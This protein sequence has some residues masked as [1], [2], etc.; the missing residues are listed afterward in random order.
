LQDTLTY[1]SLKA[2][3][4]AINNGTVTGNIVIKIEGDLVITDPAILQASGTGNA[5]YTSVLIYP[6][7]NYTISGNIGGNKALITLLDADNVTIDGR[8]NATGATP[9]LTIQNLATATSA[10][11]W[12]ARSTTG[13]G[14][15]NVN[16]RYL[17]IVGGTATTA[18]VYGILSGQYSTT[19]LTTAGKNDS[20]KIFNNNIYRCGYGVRVNSPSTGLRT[21][22]LEIKNNDIG[23]NAIP[24]DGCTYGVDVAYI[25]GLTFENNIYSANITSTNYPFVFRYTSNATITNSKI[26]NSTFSTTTYGFYFIQTTNSNISNLT[27]ENNSCLAGT[28]YGLFFTTS[29]NGNNVNNLK[30]SNLSGASSIYGIYI[31]STSANN[32]IENVRIENL[33]STGTGTVSGVYNASGANNVFNKFTIKNLK[34]GGA[35]FGIYLSTAIT[36]I[37]KNSE[38]TNIQ[39]T[40]TYTTLIICGIYIGT[41][42]D[43]IQ[44]P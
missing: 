14:A 31:A 40:S 34:S 19:S 4:D 18:S 44:Q 39:T 36:N 37:V 23:N 3:F 32:S 7:G 20:L 41:S 25:D 15:T 16:L 42:S 12:V 24:G 43:G 22:A 21:F 2:A 9:S 29:S 10:C 5:N 13:N 35:V 26:I 30:I 27:V 33:I 11:I 8:I 1:T 6:T 28:A 38:I 17:N